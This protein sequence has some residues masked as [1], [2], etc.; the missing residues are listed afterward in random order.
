MTTIEEKLIACAIEDL[1]SEMF[2]ELRTKEADEF[3]RYSKE[4]LNLSVGEAIIYAWTLSSKHTVPT[5]YITLN[6][7]YK[8]FLHSGKS[9]KLLDDAAYE[10]SV[11]FSYIYEYCAYREVTK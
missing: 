8:A 9:I 6:A 3:E 5:E 11:P 1:Y 4:E 2:G 7:I 10:L